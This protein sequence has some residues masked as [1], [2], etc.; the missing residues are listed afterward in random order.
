MNTQTREALYLAMEAI[1]E[2][3]PSISKLI[4]ALE[5]CMNALEQMEGKTQ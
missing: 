2:Y 5:H 3:P 4:I 1:N